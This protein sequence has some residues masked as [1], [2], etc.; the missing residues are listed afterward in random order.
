[1]EYA[2][3][4][5]L[6]VESIAAAAVLVAAVLFLNDRRM[7][8]DAELEDRASERASLMHLVDN[9]MHHNTAA[10]EANTRE[11]QAASDAVLRLAGTL[12]DLADRL[13][14]R[15]CMRERDAAA[16]PHV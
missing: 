13:A 14:T 12:D 4:G 5:K 1:M 2:L 10:I 11:Q 16:L 8:R 7:A 15:P 9:A 6:I 3:I